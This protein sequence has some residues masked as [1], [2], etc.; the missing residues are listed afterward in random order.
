MLN[1]KKI[2]GLAAAALMASVVSAHAVPWTLSAPPSTPLP[3][4]F[5]PDLPNS[6]PASIAAGT[7]VA[8]SA[9]LGLS[10]AAPAIKYTFLGKEASFVN[11]S[12]NFLGASVLTNTQATGTSVTTPGPIG[13][14]ATLAFKFSGPSGDAVNGS[15]A[16]SPRLAF[17]LI[18]DIAYAFF[19][20][21][22]ASNDADF[23]DMIVSIEVVP[24]PAA[25]WLLLAGLGG[26]GLV[27]RRRKAA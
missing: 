2:T 4:S 15:P 19:D 12:F 11:S 24:L 22:G 14:I 23:D 10:V 20:D 17:L 21:G 3:A 1:L 6:V 9:T 5:N 25:A 27:A 16:V 8:V 26:M 7:N 13:P 18:G